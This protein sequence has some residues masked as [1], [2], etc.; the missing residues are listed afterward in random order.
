MKKHILFLFLFLCVLAQSVFAQRTP[1]EFNNRMAG[2]TDSLYARGQAWGT[3]FNNARST[4]NFA[5]LKSQRQE[6]ESFVKAKMKEVRHMKHIGDSRPLRNAMK[7]FLKVEENMITT[8][9]IPIERLPAT[10]TNDQVDKAVQALQDASVKEAAALKAVTDAQEAYA[11]KN[12]F[13]IEPD[14]G[15]N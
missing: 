11:Q 15:R 8:G 9:F 3:A 1:L 13:R 4:K 6:I 7:A 14:N 5:S 12:G 2:I 10:V